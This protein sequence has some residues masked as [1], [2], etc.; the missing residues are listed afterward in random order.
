MMPNCLGKYAQFE[1]TFIFK[2]SPLY[3]MVVVLFLAA[4]FKYL[5]IYSVMSVVP[6]R[7]FATD[8]PI[9]LFFSQQYI[10]DLGVIVTSDLTYHKTHRIDCDS[11][12]KKFLHGLKI[13]KTLLFFGRYLFLSSL[14]YIA[15]IFGLPG[16]IVKLNVEEKARQICISLSQHYS[17]LCW[18]NEWFQ[19][20]YF[21]GSTGSCCRVL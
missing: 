2:T 8:Y 1:T 19:S 4:K 10:K 9:R 12:Y 11:R 15:L 21:S 20:A 18:V 5:K 14:L 7:I 17:L 13:P 16:Q 3:H 6:I